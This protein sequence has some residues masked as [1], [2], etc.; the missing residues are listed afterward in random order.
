MTGEIEADFLDEFKTNDLIGWICLKIC[1]KF[2]PEEYPK[3]KKED[4]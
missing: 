4:D 3:E 2:F 1:E